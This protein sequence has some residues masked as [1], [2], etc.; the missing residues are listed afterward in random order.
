MKKVKLYDVIFPVWFIWLLPP[1]ILIA[2][3]GNFVIDTIVM[4]IS[5]KLIKAAE[6]T[7]LSMKELYKKSIIKV[8]CLGFLADIIGALI[9]LALTSDEIPS[10]K[11]PNKIQNAI[12]MNPFANIWAFLIVFACMVIVSIF[13]YVFNYNITFKKVIREKALKVKMSLIFAIVTA[14][15]TFLIPTKWFIKGF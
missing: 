9:L 14:P 4:L 11:I 10:L 7:G 5:F 8:W 12:Y 2:F 3:A 13:I 15:W 6:I 1:I